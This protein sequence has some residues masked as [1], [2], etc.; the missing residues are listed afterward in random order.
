MRKNYSIHFPPLLALFL[1]IFGGDVVSA[2]SVDATWKAG[3][4]KAQITPEQPLW[5]SGYAS[6]D[7]PSEGTRVDLWVKALALQ[8]AGG[9]KALLI[10]LDLV[11]ID[12]GISAAICS[13]L[14][15]RH[16]LE[17]SQILLSTSHT[18]T[19]PVVGEN[20]RAMYSFPPGMWQRVEAY[21]KQLQEKIETAA[22]AAIGRLEPARLAWGSGTAGIG[23]NRRNNTEADV[24]K[25]RAEGKLKGPVDHDVPVLSVHDSKG[26]L[27]AATFGY[28]CH[29]T[30]L[31][32]YKWSGDYP[33]YAQVFFEQAYPG[34]V[35]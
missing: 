23:V 7:R 18:H 25:L 28:A 35:G 12:R 14:M 31:S 30:V 11:G 15:Q 9:R 13:R 21:T 5:L 6:R 27:V 34:A 26:H 1:V 2:V 29:A 4:A 20:L 17:R 33:G 22:A 10:T 19:G 24:P 3:V 16:E 8:D 32:D